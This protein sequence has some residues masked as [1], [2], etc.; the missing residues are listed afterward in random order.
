MIR[1]IKLIRSR[2]VSIM[3]KNWKNFWGALTGSEVCCWIGI[4]FMLLAYVLESSF[5]G[6]ISL[7][8]ILLSS[9]TQGE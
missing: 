3:N 7:V 9:A 2:M 1:N 5:L 6:F 8:L 4:V